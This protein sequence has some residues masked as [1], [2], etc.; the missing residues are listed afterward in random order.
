M[1]IILLT[2]LICGAFGSSYAQ[3]IS[4]SIKV[5]GR[6]RSFS[7]QNIPNVQRS[8]AVIFILHGSGG[9]GKDMMQP[10]AGLQKIAAAERLL[11]VYPDGY[12]RYWNECR[13]GATSE[14]NQININEQ[15]FFEGMISYLSSRYRVNTKSFFAVGLSGGGHMA[16][17]LG[18]QMPTRF[19]A[20]SAI[21][22]NLPDTLNLDCVETKKPLAVLIA[23][24]TKDPLN[25]Y[26]GGDIIIDG[27]NWGAVRSTD[28]TFAYWA[29]L[30]GYSGDPV[31]SA[32]PDKDTTNGQAIT[33]YTYRQKG[34]PEVALLK[35][36]GGA[37][38]FPKDVDIFL[39]SWQFFKRE[40]VR[41]A[42]AS[43]KSKPTL[44]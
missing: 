1:K 21:V 23:N 19:R 12:K 16:Y 38:A 4:D 37:H 6:F 29:R 36:D 39:E 17:K 35:V 15:G 25:H 40:L 43:K 10:S 14:A 42:S 22:A 34:K 41:E 18:M 20:V 28:R 24:G 9:T 11:L 31:V 7:F 2:L 8:R 32:L 33:R 44:K 13:K 3:Y 30:A 26:E 27:R 5:D